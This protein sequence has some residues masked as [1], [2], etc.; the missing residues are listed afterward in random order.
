MCDNEYNTNNKN[1]GVMA[2][3]QLNVKLLSKTE[4]ALEI[5]YASCRQC[6]STDFAGDIFNEVKDWYQNDML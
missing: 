5:I 4:N 3:V 2:E 1:G 6:Y